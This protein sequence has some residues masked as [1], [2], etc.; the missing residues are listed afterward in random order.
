MNA[1]VAAYRTLVGVA[2]VAGLVIAGVFELTAPAIASNRIEQLRS[3]I[4]MVVPG[5]ER[6]QA[7]ALEGQRVVE[8][9]TD[10]GASFYAAYDEA[11]VLAGF[12]VRA[13]AMGYQDRIVAL[14]GYDH[15]T[16]TV[17]GLEILQSL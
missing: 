7:Y 1:P 5:A 8:R 4:G 14:Y 2:L 16:Q 11:G 12:A 17:T 15:A 6:W 10:G 13:E 9:A 3:A